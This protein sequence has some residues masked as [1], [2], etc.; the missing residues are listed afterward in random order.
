MQYGRAFRRALALTV[1]GLLVLAGLALLVLPGPGLLL[2]L[3]GLVVLA[4]EFP[5]VAR[6]VA[7]VRERAM[8]AAE[9]SVSSPWRIAGSVATALALAGAGV[10]WG[11]VP[12]LP[13]SGWSTGVALMISSALLCVLLVW[14]R[15]Q[16]RVQRARG[17]RP[18]SGPEPRDG[19]GR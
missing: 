11:L 6:F 3:A 4:Q 1:G 10:V 9:D 17:E 12:A 19:R 8:K 2:V 7:P 18:P 13:F 14:S 16:V 15:Q 5:G